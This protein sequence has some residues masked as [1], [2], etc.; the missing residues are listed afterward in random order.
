MVSESD[1]N[2]N[3]WY[4]L[5]IHVVEASIVNALKQL[6]AA[7]IEPILIK[8]LAISQMYPENHPRIFQD[9]DLCVNPFEYQK[10]KDILEKNAANFMHVDLHQGLRHL[11][12]VSWEDLY[13]NSRLYK[14]EETSIR[15]LRPEDHLRVVCTHWL[16]DG[17]ARKDRLWDIF[18]AVENR[19]KDFEWD[20]FLE[21]SGSKRRKWFVCTLG[22]AHKYL[23]LNLKETPIA[24]EALSIPK[25]I[26]KTVEKEWGSEIR[27]KALQGCL[28]NKKELFEQIKKRIPPN[29]IQAT[30]EMEGDFDNKPRIFYQIGDIF[31]RMPKSI[32]SVSESIFN[33][34]KNK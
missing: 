6:R 25:W 32:K 33:K 34:Y 21:I 9:V 2:I 1:K 19:P 10:A 15:I 26:I 22:L 7:Q 29:P 4:K 24:K 13:E 30:I 28:Q 14:L 3:R 8:G 27:L 23:G 17:G 5:Q 11:D 12:N 18:Y 31:F 16:N 20:R